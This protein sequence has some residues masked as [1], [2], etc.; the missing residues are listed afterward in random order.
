M[1]QKQ[2]FLNSLF[3][4]I[5]RTHHFTLNERA[6]QPVLHLVFGNLIFVS[7]PGKNEYKH[8]HFYTNSTDS[9][10]AERSVFFLG[11][12]N[13]KTFSLLLNIHRN[14]SVLKVLLFL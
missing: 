11:L 3:A 14:V 1:A 10:C 12:S 2:G 13:K 9:K 7:L 5:S 4:G 6:M 8:L